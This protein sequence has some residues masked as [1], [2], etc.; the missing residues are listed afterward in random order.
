[1][2]QYGMLIVKNGFNR[3][4]AYKLGARTLTA[5]R[6]I[7]NLIQLIDKEVSRRHFQIR[8]TPTGYFLRDMNS[9]NGTFVNGSQVTEKHLQIGDVIKAGNT[10]M[11]LMKHVD[12][13]KDATFDR[14]V[15]DRQ[16][17]GGETMAASMEDFFEMDLNGGPSTIID[18]EEAGA[19]RMSKLDRS[20]KKMEIADEYLDITCSLVM[21][22]ICPDRII[23]FRVV[24]GGKIRSVKLHSHPMLSE[25]DKRVRPEQGIV[26]M[27]FAQKSPQVNN[28]IKTAE[29]RAP[30][31]VLVVPVTSD[32]RMKG[33]VYIDTMPENRKYFDDTDISLIDRIAEILAR[34]W[35]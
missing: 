23:L 28:S 15:V 22:F 33:V 16:L 25:K 3:G 35:Q 29:G 24:Q 34:R 17:V 31:S 4:N 30:G 5:G 14:K 8:W 2:A 27:A 21:D 12:Q 32:N 10:Q 9:A 11:E 13:V 19:K 18:V 6:D 7:G 26:R 1:M 20:L